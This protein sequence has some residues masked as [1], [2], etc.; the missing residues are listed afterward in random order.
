M[1]L[2]TGCLA[3]ALAAIHLLVGRLRF[4]DSVP[5]SIW[6]S[7]AGGVAVAYVFLHLL[8][9]LVA[10]QETLA[11]GLGLGP[12]VA[13]VTIFGMALAGV[14]AFYGLER[15]ARGSW[16]PLA[17]PVDDAGNVR[18][19]WIHIGA[20]ALYNAL[21][22][23]L[24]VHPEAP[25]LDS[26][27]LFFAAMAMHFVTNDF[28]MRDHHRLRYDAVGRWVLAGAVLAGWLLGQLTDLPDLAI[29]LLF[30]FL[31]GGVMLNVLKEELPE[32][33]QSR[34]LPFLAGALGYSAL[35]VAF[36]PV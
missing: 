5:R 2:L 10:H 32:D 30:S 11:A 14:T 19:F 23:Y 28:G 35:L 36:N 1:T 15:L 31:A 8:P 4:L 6:L 25:G 34:F 12:D 7:G 26:A 16:Q 13:E 3:T 22:G 20:F 9:D 21:I 27:L 24:L 18:V 29:A 17:T 33:R